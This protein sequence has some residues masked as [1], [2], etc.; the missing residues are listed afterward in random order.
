MRHMRGKPRAGRRIA[1]RVAFV[2]SVVLGGFSSSTLADTFL[3]SL[4]QSVS[5]HHSTRHLAASGGAAL[6][7]TKATVLPTTK[8]PASPTPSADAQGQRSRAPNQPTS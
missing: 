7:T 6:P 8:A 3:A 1:S 5:V 2:V 4:A